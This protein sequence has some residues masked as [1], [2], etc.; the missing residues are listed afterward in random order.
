[1]NEIIVDLRISRDEYLKLYRGL[2]QVVSTRALDG[3]RVQFPANI[4]RP[5]VTHA[6]I[7]GRFLI[8]FTAA[9]KFSD[10]RRLG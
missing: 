3:R 4:L 9:G 6:G 2:S 7:H 10:I 8:R 5:W 1:M